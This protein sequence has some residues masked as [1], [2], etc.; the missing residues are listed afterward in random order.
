MKLIIVR[1]LS[2]HWEWMGVLVLGE[3]LGERLR[4]QLKTGEVTVAG[5]VVV[6]MS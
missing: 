2:M 3:G 6:S 1:E 5:W 4:V